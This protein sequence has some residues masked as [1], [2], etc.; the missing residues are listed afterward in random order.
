MF[1]N[2][3]NGGFRNFNDQRDMTYSYNDIIITAFDKTLQPVWNNIINKSTQDIETDNYLSFCNANT[4]KELH[5]VFLQKDNNR[6]VLS[7]HSLQFNGTMQRNATIKSGEN[8]FNFMPRLARQT[9]AK[10][11]LVPCM[12]RN[13]LAF[14]KIDL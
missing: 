11:L 10:Q 3:M 14:A 7:N 4:G 12:Q 2:G 5:F 8:G 9:G 13:T 1:N 6:Q